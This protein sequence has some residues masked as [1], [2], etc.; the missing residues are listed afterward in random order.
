MHMLC[1]KFHKAGD[2]MF[3]QAEVNLLLLQYVKEL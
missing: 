1:V 2:L 3:L